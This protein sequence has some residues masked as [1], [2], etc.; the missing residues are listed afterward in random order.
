[1]ADLNDPDQVIRNASPALADEVRKCPRMPQR[2]GVDV[3]L[4]LP[5]SASFPKRSRYYGYAG[6][7]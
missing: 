3:C 2:S 7:V 6:R 5:M 1:M 4:R